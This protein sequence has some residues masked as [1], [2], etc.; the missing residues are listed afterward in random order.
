MLHKVL[1]VSQQM[2]VIL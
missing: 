1:Q 2:S